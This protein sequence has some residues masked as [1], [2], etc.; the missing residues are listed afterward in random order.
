MPLFLCCFGFDLMLV[1]IMGAIFRP[2]RLVSALAQFIPYSVVLA[3]VRGPRPD[4]RQAGQADPADGVVS[5]GR[6]R[7]FSGLTFPTKN[8]PWCAG[9]LSIGD[10]GRFRNH[11]ASLAIMVAVTSFPAASYFLVEE[12]VQANRQPDQ[13]IEV[14]RD[15]LDHVKRMQ[16]LLPICMYRHK[17]RTDQQSWQQIELYIHEHSEAT[18]THGMCPD[19]AENYHPELKLYSQTQSRPP[20]EP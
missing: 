8:L 9:V 20:S 11:L 10:R 12:I 14:L 18:F 17:I 16:G 7:G 6:V 13:Q 1:Q 2:G 3:A 5:D 15:A 4:P 19:C